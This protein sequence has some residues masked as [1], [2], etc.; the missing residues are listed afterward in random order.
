[1]RK[2]SNSKPIEAFLMRHCSAPSLSQRPAAANS[3]D[4][5]RNVLSSE[6]HKNAVVKL[7]RHHVK[8]GRLFFFP[9]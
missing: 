1:M 5:C 3:G 8:R 9:I 2:T 7:Y 6:H 4:S